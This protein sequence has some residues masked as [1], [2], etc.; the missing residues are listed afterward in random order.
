MFAQFNPKFICTHSH[1]L[2]HMSKLSG[3]V[4]AR[5]PLMDACATIV[6]VVTFVISIKGVRTA[7]LSSSLAAPLGQGGT[8]LHGT[9]NI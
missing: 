8:W 5:A 9:K 7:G 2:V 3:P 6:L 1:L 4:D